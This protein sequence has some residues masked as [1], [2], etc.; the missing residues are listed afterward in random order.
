MTS[1]SNTPS[2]G[3]YKNNSAAY[4]APLGL[5]E[6]LRGRR[7][8]VHLGS[9]GQVPATVITRGN[10]NQPERMV[11]PP[12]TSH[13][14]A[15]TQNCPWESQPPL[16]DRFQDEG[17]NWTR[18]VTD[19]HWVPKKQN[20]DPPKLL[21][22]DSWNLA[23]GLKVANKPAEM[24]NYPGPL[25]WAQCDP[26]VPEGGQEAGGSTQELKNLQPTIKDLEGGQRGHKASNSGQK[27]AR[28]QT[29]PWSPREASVRPC[30]DQPCKTP[31]GF[32]D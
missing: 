11:A 13:P 27:K 7:T 21:R 10:T 9:G 16:G 19:L 4:K 6:T 14:R 12:T 31:V 17:F 29:P 25:M 28:E 3:S 22:P 23:R 26:G 2:L 1:A 32:W 15:S 30:P 8:R 24:G 20:K 5:M 18:A